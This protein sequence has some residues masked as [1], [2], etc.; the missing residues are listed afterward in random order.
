MVCYFFDKSSG[1]IGVGI[2]DGTKKYFLAFICAVIIISILFVGTIGAIFILR[3]ISFDRLFQS[4]TSEVDHIPSAVSYGTLYTESTKINLSQ[5]CRKE[6]K[7]GSFKEVFCIA[8]N[9]AYF[10]Y[11]MSIP[12]GFHWFLASLDLNTLAMENICSLSNA[13]K[14]YTINRTVEYKERCGYYANGQII[15]NDSDTVFVY[16][17]ESGTAKSYTYEEYNFPKIYVAGEMIDAN[18][19]VLY[20]GENKQTFSLSEMAEGSKSIEYIYELR[21]KKTWNGT[22]CISGFFLPNS[23]QMIGDKIYAVG[24]CLNFSGESYAIVFEYNK[25]SESW[26]FATVF[27]SGDTI[28]R[29]CYLVEQ[30]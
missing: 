15:L 25:D 8:D 23:I 13:K 5:I 12:T 6:T 22:P 18:T 30:M 24:E 28:S 11:T 29:E 27:F 10:S 7:N 19:V 1:N 21:N 14:H 9:K 2:M 4:V 16:T 26:Q 20:I 3:K 17:I